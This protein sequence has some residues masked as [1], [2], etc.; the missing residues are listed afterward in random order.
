MTDDLKCSSLSPGTED[1]H[2]SFP[3]PVRLSWFSELVCNVPST[4]R[5][6]VLCFARFLAGSLVHSVH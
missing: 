2:C 3:R 4:T 5:A 1:A 6:V